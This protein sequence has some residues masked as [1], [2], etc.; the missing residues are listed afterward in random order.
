VSF[1]PGA[2]YF[3][4]SKVQR[5]KHKALVL[6]NSIQL[7]KSAQ[8]RNDHPFRAFNTTGKC[9]TIARLILAFHVI[10]NLTVCAFT[11]PTE[12]SVRDRVYG[13]ILKTAE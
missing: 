11:I 3:E 2:L 8:L 5:S 13:Q 10:P 4:P 1:V 9:W 7:N 6:C 12:V